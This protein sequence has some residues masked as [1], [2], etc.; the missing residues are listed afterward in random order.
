MT[1]IAWGTDALQSVPEGFL[2]EG[3]QPAAG[4]TTFEVFDP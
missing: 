3:W 1:T 2:A 4:G